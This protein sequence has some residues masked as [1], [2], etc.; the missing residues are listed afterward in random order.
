MNLSK[1]QTLAAESY[2]QVVAGQNLT[3]VMAEVIEKNPQL[4][5][6][7]RGM[8]QDLCYGVQRYRGTLQGILAVLVPKKLNIDV[9]EALLLVAMY[10]VLYTKNANH[11][12]VN[13][14]VSAVDSAS[15]GRLKSLS[16][17]VLRRL[18][19]EESK[20]LEQVVGRSDEAKYNYPMWW[21]KAVQKQHPKYWHNILQA[22]QK[23]PPLTLR[24]N[25]RKTSVE[26][27]LMVLEKE[28]ISAKALGGEAVVLDQAIAVNKIPFFHDGWVSVQDY[29]A[30]QAAH[31]LE[32]KA[33]ERILDACAAPGGKTCHLLE[34]ADCQVLALDIAE[35][36][37]QK[38]TD[39][40]DRLGLSV[41]VRCADAAQL[42]DWYDGVGFDAILADVPCTAS[43]VTKRHPDIKWLRQK[44]DSLKI[45]KQQYAL[46]DSL[47][48]TL[49]PNGRMLLATCS[50]FTPENSGQLQKFLERHVDAVCE[51]EHVLLPNNKQDGFYYALLRKN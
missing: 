22:T 47:W 17:A 18:L 20:L 6:G 30:Q 32:P 19:R 9:V 35:N 16:N 40:A 3:D 43:G 11:A 37:L 46:L 29:G 10:Q 25:I 5:G 14:V 1:I 28:G 15:N 50:I 31:V 48:K 38:V 45:A 7:H 13:E 34:L 23:H 36:R 26:Q 42:D 41:D 51:S 2:L 39:N 44:E 4:V 21:I 8:Y 27:Y 12:V 33:G 49:K 24:V